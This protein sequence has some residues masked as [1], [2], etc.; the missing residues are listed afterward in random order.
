M[1]KAEAWLQCSARGTTVTR[2]AYLMGFNPS[3]VKDRGTHAHID[4]STEKE[5]EKKRERK[6]PRNPRRHLGSSSE[7]L[8]PSV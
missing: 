8:L 5:R 2:L 3:C 4:R 1:T 7:F 6:E